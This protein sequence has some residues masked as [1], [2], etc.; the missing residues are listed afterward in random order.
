M[1]Y[2]GRFSRFGGLGGGGMFGPLQGGMPGGNMAWGGN[3]W[4]PPGQNSQ[5]I[6]GATWD[7]PESRGGFPPANPNVPAPIGG[8]PGMAGDIPLSELG[9]GTPSPFADTP[10]PFGGGPGMA[11]D[12]PFSEFGRGYG[13]P[14]DAGGPVSQPFA[15]GAPNPGVMDMVQTG[16]NMFDGSLTG[17]GMFSQPPGGFTP[18]ASPV[19]A[20]QMPQPAPSAPKVDQ[21]PAPMPQAFGGF[22]PGYT[23]Q[24]Q[25]TDPYGQQ[26]GLTPPPG[27]PG[28]YG[29][30]GSFS[31][32]PPSTPTWV[33]S[34]SAGYMGMGGGTPPNPNMSWNPVTRQWGYPGQ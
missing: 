16:G 8:G 15:R 11:G 31:F 20:P 32:P 13:G 3:G 17:G 6:P 18:G 19:P 34:V 26:K 5:P 21:A 7:L 4:T 29:P 23:P 28:P 33:P 10:A 12:I 30:G 22:A 24:P 27:T 9:R 14:P 2:A 25:Q 1:N